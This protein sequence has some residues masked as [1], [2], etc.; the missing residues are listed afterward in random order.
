MN[1]TTT[2]TERERV[3]AALHTFAHQ[4][5]RL[6]RLNYGDRESF[7]AEARAITAQLRDARLLLRAVEMRGGISVAEI[8]NGFS[9]GSGR[10]SWDGQ[11]LDYTTG[12][13]WATEYRAAVCAGLSRVLWEFF[14]DCAP[15]DTFATASYIRDEATRQLGRPLA[16]RWFR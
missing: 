3:L 7:R 14:R 1:T 16:A 5:P 13:Y 12:Q 11:R 4:H 15:P 10:L 2:T 8:E 6:E 9:A